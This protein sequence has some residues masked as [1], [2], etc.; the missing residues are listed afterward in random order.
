MQEQRMAR[1]TDRRAK[2]GELKKEELS[3]PHNEEPVVIEDL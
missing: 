1:E 2:R 3:P